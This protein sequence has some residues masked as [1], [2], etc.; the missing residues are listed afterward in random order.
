[1][2]WRGDYYY[3]SERV[4]GQPRQVYVGAGVIGQLAA[5]LDEAERERRRLQEA[6]ADPDRVGAEAQDDGVRLVERLADGLA[7]AALYAAGYRRHHRGEW[8]RKREA[9]QHDAGKAGRPERD[10]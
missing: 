5:Q 2:P 1:M 7:R 10:G 9:K 8:R 6:G 4:N 3:R